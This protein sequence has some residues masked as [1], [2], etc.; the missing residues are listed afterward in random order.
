MTGLAAILNEPGQQLY[1]TALRNSIFRLLDD[2]DFPAEEA[3]AGRTWVE[4]SGRSTQALERLMDRCIE[5]LRE[6][7]EDKL[8]NPA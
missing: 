4:A 3:Q 5:R 8:L 2:E 6:V 7:R 1:R